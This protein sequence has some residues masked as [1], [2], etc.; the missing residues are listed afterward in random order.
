MSK[1]RTSDPC[2][3]MVMT[4]FLLTF[5]IQECDTPNDNFLAPHDAA[6]ESRLKSAS[7]KLDMLIMGLPDSSVVPDSAIYSGEYSDSQQDQVDWPN[8]SLPVCLNKPHLQPSK[9]ISTLYSMCETPTHRKE[10]PLSEEYD[11]R[12]FSDTD[13]KT[14]NSCLIID[15]GCNS[16]KYEDSKDPT[17]LVPRYSSLRNKSQD[18]VLQ[19]FKKSFSLRFHKNRQ[20]ESSTRSSSPRSGK[21]SRSDSPSQFYYSLEHD[22]TEFLPSSHPAAV[23]GVSPITSRKNDMSS[24]SIV[25]FICFCS[26]IALYVPKNDNYR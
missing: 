15:D 11:D 4:N 17:H 22:P 9:S 2:L 25:Y 21:A 13:L 18:S 14:N 23:S 26:N 12:H 8:C 19:K 24:V 3:A 1:L 5:Q 16:P 20:S 10:R 6:E 7:A